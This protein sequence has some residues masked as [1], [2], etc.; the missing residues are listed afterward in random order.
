MKATTGRSPNVREIVT[1]NYE[2][3]DAQILALKRGDVDFISGEFG[4]SPRKA[5]A[6]KNNPRYRH[7]SDPLGRAGLRG[8]VYV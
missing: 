8:G 2:D 6:L 5:E 4:L 3:E 7:M 1:K